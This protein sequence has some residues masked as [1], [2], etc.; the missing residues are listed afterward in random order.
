ME[1]KGIKYINPIFDGSGYSQAGRQ[2]VLALHKLG[3]PITISPVS[4]ELA[5]PSL[6]EDEKILRSLVNKKIDYNIVLCHTTPEFWEKFKE[7]DKIFIGYTIWETSKL[8]SSWPK[9]IN[10]TADLCMVGCD[11]NVGVFKDSGVSVPIVNI[12]HIIDANEFKNI[13]PYNI[14]GIDTSAYVYYF[15]GQWCYD[16]Q[17]RV[18]T[19]E[20]FKYFKDLLYED[21]IATL[22]KENDKLEYHKPDKIVKF[23]RKDKMLHLNSSGQYD[24]CVTPDHKMVVKTKYDESWQLKPL[25]ELLAKTTDGKLKVSNIYRSKKNCIWEGKEEEY[26]YLCNKEDITVDSKKIRMDDFLEF[27]G[28][29]LSE[30]SLERSP[31]YYR[32]VITQLKSEQ[33]KKEI[34]ECI[35][36]M[37]FTPVNH[38]NKDILFNSKYLYFYLLE[39]GKCYEKFIPAWLK[40]LSSDQI[41]IFLN[42]LI[43]GDGS[44]SKNGSW[45]KYTTTSK[46]LAEDVQECLLKVGFSGS[47]STCDPTTKKYEMIDGRLI[48]GTRLQ[49]TISVNKQQNE[50]SLSRARLDEIDYDGYVYCATVKNHTMLVERNG[51]ILFSGNTERKNVLATIKTYWRTFR[52]G[53]NVAL[54]MKTYRS[55]YSEPEKDAIRMTIKRLKSVC[56]MEGYTYP[57][58]YLVL[59]MLSDTE[60]KGLH[61]RGN[62]YISLDRGEGF[63]LSTA[64]AGA[65]GNPVI[66][67]GFGGATEYLKKDNSYLVDYVET[68]CHGMPWSRWYS[69]DQYWAFPNEKHASELMRYTY[70][71]QTDAKNV[72]LKL[73]SDIDK[74]LNWKVIGHKIIDAIGRL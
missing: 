35:E 53:E 42:S 4:F 50:P 20:G 41:K 13:T 47:I 5:K 59:D 2:Y 21:E 48:K 1:I 27:L 30:G 58:V 68:C 26:F 25:N 19:R 40:N 33:Y 31:N 38:N 44:F 69:L 62:C 29:Y 14:N 17:T 6:G 34:W 74:N 7:P 65:A 43:K 39:F 32:V 57:P 22:N 9:Y 60:I 46:K 36:R 55:D 28:W 45:M 67:T 12:P 15:I 18:L 63:G 56:A 71:N 52:R 61:A 51:K 16:E 8:H 3:I 24:I 54:V 66:A 64:T 37:G 10:D 72:G 73:Q 23:R 70:E 49:Y 11:W